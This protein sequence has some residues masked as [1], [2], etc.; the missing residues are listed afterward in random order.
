MKCVICEKAHLPSE[1]CGLDTEAGLAASARLDRARAVLARVEA[2][3]A[4]EA[5]KEAAVHGQV[6]VQDGRVLK[7]EEVLAPP[8]AKGFDRNAYHKIYMRAYMRR[9]RAAAKASGVSA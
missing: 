9:R 8:K 6:F 1:R 5:F 3:V 7:P 2:P 4:K